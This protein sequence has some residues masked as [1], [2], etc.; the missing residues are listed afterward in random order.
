MFVALVD[1]CR[2]FP[3]VDVIQPASDQTEALGREILDRRREFELSVEPRFDRMLIGRRN[4]EKVSGKQGA[5][6][7]GD[8]FLDKRVS[9]RALGHSP[10]I[11]QRQSEH[12]G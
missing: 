11:Q 4:I 9:A 2:C 7:T 8:Y 10:L 3:T 1:E 6:V 5:N 12:D